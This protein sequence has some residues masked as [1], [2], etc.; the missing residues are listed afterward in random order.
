[1]AAA[2]NRGEK[3]PVEKDRGKL[4]MYKREYGAFRK[5]LRA[6]EPEGPN[7]HLWSALD[8]MLYWE[9]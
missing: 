6:D 9:H 8:Q 3:S 1:M 4:G 7:I 2:R 5:A